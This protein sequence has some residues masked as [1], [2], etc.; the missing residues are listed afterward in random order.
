MVSVAIAVMRL[1]GLTLRKRT[2]ALEPIA[3]ETHTTIAQKTL[4][5]FAPIIA[6]NVTMMIPTLETTISLALHA[7][8]MD[9]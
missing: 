9:G 1:L 5:C 8:M 3:K 2:V 6:Q 7:I 4:V